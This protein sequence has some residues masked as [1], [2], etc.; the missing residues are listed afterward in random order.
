MVTHPQIES[1]ASFTS[2]LTLVAGK[3]HA[4]AVIRHRRRSSN[5]AADALAETLRKVLPGLG[6]EGVVH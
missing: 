1:V 3:H 5:P 4:R 6:G 2:P